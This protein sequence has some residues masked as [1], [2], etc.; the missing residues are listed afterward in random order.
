[1]L[2]SYYCQKDK[3]D[4]LGFLIDSYLGLSSGIFS[5]DSLF[6]LESNRELMRK[7]MD[8]YGFIITSILT[9]STIMNGI[10][11]SNPGRLSAEDRPG[12]QFKHYVNI[13][14]FK[15]SVKLWSEIRRMMKSIVKIVDS[16]FEQPIRDDSGSITSLPILTKIF[17]TK[18]LNKPHP[19]QGGKTMLD[20]LMEE[21]PSEKDSSVMKHNWRLIGEEWSSTW[22]HSTVTRKQLSS[23]Q[24]DL[25]ATWMVQDS[26]TDSGLDAIR[27]LSRSQKSTL[28]SMAD[29]LE[30]MIQVLRTGSVDNSYSNLQ[31]LAYWEN[32]FHKN[33]NN[34]HSP[35]DIQGNFSH[36]LYI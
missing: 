10:S 11:S 3:T 32:F 27:K 26:D 24:R 17:N 36:I 21:N 31:L 22:Y 2:S 15:D 23:D 19:S 18:M 1:M 20:W 14:E 28:L 30:S 34:I 33:G 13:R 5:I 29:V 6:G 4:D 16:G 25:I 35:Y 8:L 7:R 12:V 9:S